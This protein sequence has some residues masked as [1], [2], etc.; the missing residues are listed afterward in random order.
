[1]H[2]AAAL[3][4]SN[5]LK[6]GVFSGCGVVKMSYFAIDFEAEMSY[7]LAPPQGWEEVRSLKISS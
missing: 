7:P 6:D 3:S 4:P 5:C 1:M 2:L